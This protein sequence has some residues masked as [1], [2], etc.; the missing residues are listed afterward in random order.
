MNALGGIALDAG[1]VDSARDYFSAAAGSE[2]EAGRRARTALARLDLPR[3]PQ[4]YLSVRWG[5]DDQGTLMA[6]VRNQAPLDVKELVLE[7]ALRNP[8]GEVERRRVR[9]DGS[10]AAGAGTR[11]S[12]GVRLPAD[13][14]REAIAVRVIQ[15]RVA[16]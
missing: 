10:L 1:R 5:L 14:P 8:A 7:I 12:T 16:D 11:V 6:E 3:E 2:T 4:R 9:L 13:T 15:A